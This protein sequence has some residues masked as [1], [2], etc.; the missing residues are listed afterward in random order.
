MI[1]ALNGLLEVDSLAER[2]PNAEVFVYDMKAERKIR[3]PR[4]ELYYK[5]VCKLPSPI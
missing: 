3:M 2:N 5:L 1:P 4:G